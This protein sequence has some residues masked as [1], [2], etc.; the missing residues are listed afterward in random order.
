VLA[1]AVAAVEE[2]AI[3][4]VVVEARALRVIFGATWL[5][6][7]TV[8]GGFPDLG[9]V[10]GES[11]AARLAVGGGA[12]RRAVAVAEAAGATAVDLRPV[13]DALRVWAEVAGGAVE[14]ELPLTGSGA[15]EAVK[16]DPRRLL[17]LLGEGEVT[18]S[19]AAF[20][21]VRG[22]QTDGFWLLM[23]LRDEA[24]AAA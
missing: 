23:P 18:L 15:L 9:I 16:I 20:G 12:L 2:D 24:R 13:G 7:P 10:A 14:T 17:G 4:R 19:W 6:V 1:R 5:T 3:A 22:D 11:A 21:P 8:D